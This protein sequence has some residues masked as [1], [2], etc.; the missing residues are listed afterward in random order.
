MMHVEAKRK[1]LLIYR[2]QTLGRKEGTPSAKWMTI[3]KLKGTA[4]IPHTSNG[5][6]NVSNTCDKWPMRPLI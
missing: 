5:L 6:Q 2:M 4:T 3:W 1:T